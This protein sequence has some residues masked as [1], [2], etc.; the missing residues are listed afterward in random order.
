MF[1]PYEKKNVCENTKANETVFDIDQKF[2][3]IWPVICYIEIEMYEEVI[4]FIR[5][6]V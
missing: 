6:A 5:P 2:R 4:L 1:L 3:K